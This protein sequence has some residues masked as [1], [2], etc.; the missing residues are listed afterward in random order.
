[1]RARM[2]RGNGGNLDGVKNAED[3]QLPFLGQVR[4]V[5]EE[6]KGDMHGVKLTGE[7]A[8]NGKRDGLEF[9]LGGA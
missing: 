9:N 3:I 1:V 6:G 4:G 7:E 2:Y 5:G 8:G